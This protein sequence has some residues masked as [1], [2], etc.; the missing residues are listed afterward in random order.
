MTAVWEVNT[1]TIT[2]DSDGGSSV[3]SQTVEYN[4]V[5]TKPSNPTKAGYTFKE[6]QLNGKTYNFT[7][8]VT[9]DITLKATWTK[10]TTK[11]YTFE[12]TKVDPYTPDYTIT[13]YEDGNKINFSLIKLDGYTLCTGT[14]PT[15]SE[16][17]I[18]NVTSLVVVLTSGQEVT[19]TKK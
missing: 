2:F 13:V 18:K 14:N 9:K 3:E 7:T 15:V 1:Y 6:W 11:T 12:A 16:Y 10:A 4:G 8:K 5:V 17:E 19:A